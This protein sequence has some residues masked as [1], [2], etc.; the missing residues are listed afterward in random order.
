MGL[1]GSVAITGTSTVGEV[2]S[3]DMEKARSSLENFSKGGK[4]GGEAAEGLGKGLDIAKGALE[5]F[6]IAVSIGAAVELAKE[7]E[8]AG[9]AA[10]RAEA[11]LNVI[12]GNRADEYI[13]ALGKSTHGLLSNTDAATAS[14]NMLSLGLAHTSGEAAHLAEVAVTLGAAFG[15]EGAAQAIEDFDTML[16]RGATR[17]LYRFGIGLAEFKQRVDE[18]KTSHAELSETEL[19]TMAIEEL[20]SEKAAKLGGTMEDAKAHADHLASSLDNLKEKA[21]KGLAGTFGD[22]TQ[23]IANWIDKGAENSRLLE[24]ARIRI[25][26]GAQSNEGYK[27]SIDAVFDSLWRNGQLLDASIFRSN[28]YQAVTDE[29]FAAKKREAQGLVEASRAAQGNAKAEQ[30]LQ[31]AE[32]AAG[33]KVVELADKIGIYNKQLD[34]NA[35]RQLTMFD[36]LKSLKDISAGGM[37]LVPKGSPKEISDLKAAL[38]NLPPASRDAQLT[39]QKLADA[40]QTVQQRFGPQFKGVFDI[41]M[42]S[43][44]SYNLSAKE[45]LDF[46]NKLG[47]ATGQVTQKQIDQSAALTAL[48]NLYFNHKIAENDLILGELKVAG[49]MDITSAAAVTL[50]KHIQDI[51]EAAG[52]T[53]DIVDKRMIKGI[54]D[55]QGTM[56]GTTDKAS[57]I[58]KAL[59]DINDSK[60]KI[61]MDDEKVR[62][63][64]DSVKSV[65]KELAALDGQTATVHVNYQTS[66]APPPGYQHG[67]PDAPGGLALVGERGPELVVLPR[68]SQVIPNSEMSG[69][70]AGGGSFT[71][72][73]TVSVATSDAAWLVDKI[74]HE[75]RMRGKQ[76]ARVA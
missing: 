1:G 21:G 6:G 42:N 66:G 40:S 45:A 19:K 64:L 74:E 35:S 3:A 34:E 32:D 18:L 43:M 72:N 54:Q 39:L 12:T 20:A 50:A 61:N 17:G 24:T 7:L 10:L 11:S 52:Q 63:A 49:G 23:G 30:D 71:Q 46:H 27:K 57:D 14:T 13:E 28:A 25:L 69:F 36:Q 59:G 47:L 38:E 75:L 44:S 48:N 31:A 5:A 67:T 2:I 51:G 55:A 41:A 73:I 16:S 8:E 56:Q 4:A 53:G 70:G 9:A 33:K 65:E 26:A 62:A 68:H 15:H 60:T 22:I 58:S 76:L 29:N 37:A